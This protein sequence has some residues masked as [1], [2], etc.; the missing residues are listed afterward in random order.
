V[1]RFPAQQERLSTLDCAHGTTTL[2][3]RQPS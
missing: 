1:Q 3:W 2:R